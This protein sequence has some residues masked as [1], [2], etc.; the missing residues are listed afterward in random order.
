M[1]SRKWIFQWGAGLLAL[2]VSLGSSLLQAETYKPYAFDDKP[3]A[4][5]AALRDEFLELRKTGV[6]RSLNEAELKR[7]LELI[8][9][10]A[11]AEPE[12]IDGY[13]MTGEAAF[14]LGN[15]YTNPKDLQKAR[16]V[17]EKGREWTEKCLQKDE[18]NPLCKLMLG[19]AIGKIASIDGIFSSLKNAKRVQQLWTD[20]ATSGLNYPLSA[21]SSLQG[22]TN[23]ALGI[24]YRL[25]PDFFLVQWLFGVKGDIKKSVA[26]HEKTLEIDPPNACNELM[27]AASLLCLGKG[28]ADTE[29]GKKGMAMLARAKT[30]PANSSVTEICSKDI[31]KLEKD[32]SLGCGYESSRQQDTSEEEFKKQNKEAASQER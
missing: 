2:Q 26:Y 31:P 15:S 25:V 22:N 6:T 12:W 29:D 30:R 3:L 27:L 1:R 5:H 23:Y 28:K 7:H 21:T 9:T 17:F 16:A 20:A 11:K 10:I 8:E 14:L 4:K 13:W 18:K 19:A 32:P 24:F